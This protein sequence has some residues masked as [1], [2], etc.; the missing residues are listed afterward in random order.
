MC[1]QARVVDKHFGEFAATINCS[2]LCEWIRSNKRALYPNRVPFDCRLI[3]G[4]CIFFLFSARVRWCCIVTFGDQNTVTGAV[5][6]FI[7]RIQRKELSL[8]ITEI[9]FD[10]PTHLRVT[11]GRLR[12]KS[13]FRKILTKLQEWFVLKSCQI[14]NLEIKKLFFVN[15]PIFSNKNCNQK[16]ANIYH[17]QLL[18]I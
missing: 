8:C 11:V 16:A 15:K 7:L 10:S 14:G 9:K 5:K 17:K 13:D 6:S 4:F 3:S 2:S 1:K 18:K 12:F